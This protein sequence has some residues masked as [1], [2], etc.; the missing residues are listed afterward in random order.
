MDIVEN[1][2]PYCGEHLFVNKKQFAN[3]IRWCKSNPKYDEIYKN[4]TNKLK[5]NKL[6]KLNKYTFIC[7]VCGKEY[8]IELTEKEYNKHKYRK[9]CSDECAKK[10]TVLHTNLLN[11]NFNIISTFKKKY[12]KTEYI[13]KCKFCNK[14][15]KTNRINQDFCCKSCARKN[16]I[17]ENKNLY[18]IKTIYRNSCSFRFS[19]KDFPDEFDFSL[20]N[21]FGWYKA[22]NHGNNL[23]GISRDHKYSCNEGFNNL[24]DPYIISHPA[25]CQLMQ[26]SH[27]VSKY[28]KCSITLEELLNNIKLWHN[29]YGKYPN[30]INYI[31]FDKL[32]IKFLDCLL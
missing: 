21:K 26:H 9:T 30:K 19:I 16:K 17:I 15:F 5:Q 4:F 18:N 8:N 29:K 23:N 12:I 32:G 20:I 13:K 2:C 11:K 3:H 1:I 6:N 28:N 27:N 14:E 10:L 31:I 7:E 22:K 25:N 24:I